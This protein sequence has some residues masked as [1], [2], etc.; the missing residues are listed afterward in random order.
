MGSTQHTYLVRAGLLMGTMGMELG[1]RLEAGKAE[2]CSGGQGG[3]WPGWLWGVLR[4]R[5]REAMRERQAVAGEGTMP[6]NMDC[7]HWPKQPRP[8]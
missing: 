1:R 5:K 2:H 7:C 4:G 8:P 3:E 6:C